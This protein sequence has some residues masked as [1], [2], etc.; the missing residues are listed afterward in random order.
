MLNISKRGAGTVVS[1]VFFS[2]IIGFVLIVGVLALFSWNESGRQNF[3]NALQGSIDSVSS[4]FSTFFGSTLGK[5]LGFGADANTNFLMALTF[6]LISIVIVG[7]MDAANIFG[8]DKTGSLLNFIIGIIVSIIGVRFMPADIWGSLTAP[9]SAF[10]ATILVGMPFLA[11]LFVTMKVTSGPLSKGLWLFYLV[12]MTYLVFSGASTAFIWVYIIFLILAGVMIFFDSEVR[13]FFYSEKYK[14][15]VEDQIGKMS[16]RERAKL[17]TEI[18]EWQEIVADSSATSADK[19]KAK[20]ELS[21]LKKQYAD[22][23]RI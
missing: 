19:V 9:S 3:G 12:F 6:V 18:A 13:K 21:D 1:N 5:M 15:E 8:D 2:L 11:L 14:K 16:V 7:T 17:R 23:A 22:L 20:K 10:V 4:G